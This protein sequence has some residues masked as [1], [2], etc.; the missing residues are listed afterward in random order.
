MKSFETFITTFDSNIFLAGLV[1]VVMVV[2]GLVV[3]NTNDGE[4]FDNRRRCVLW[5]STNNASK[6][7]RRIKN[8]RN[9]VNTDQK[10]QQP[11]QRSASCRLECKNIISLQKVEKQ[12]CCCL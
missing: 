1:V 8:I 6:F 9:I 5:A 4:P 3:G 11:Y 2:D 10:L 12:C 7:W